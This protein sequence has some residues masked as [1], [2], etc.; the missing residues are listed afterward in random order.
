MPGFCTELSEACQ[1]FQVSIA[2][3][4][5]ENNVREVLKKKVISMQ[6]AE[7]LKVMLISSKMDHVL[8]SGR[9]YDGSIMKYLTELTFPE[10]RAIF[11]SR[12]RMW[13]TKVNFP[14]RW[15]GVLCNVCGMKDTDEH[16]FSCPGYSDILQGKFV[17]NVFW[18]DKVLNDILT[19]Q[20][21]AKTVL[22]LIE[23]MENIQKLG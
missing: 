23:R 12:Y 18:D 16:I 11:L 9:V 3:L 8:H 6:A 20:D 4:Q 15:N 19:L 22:M 10:A 5:K 2:E 13:P 1:I 17:F 7:L 21:I 14:G